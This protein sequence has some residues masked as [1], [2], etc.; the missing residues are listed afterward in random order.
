[1]RGSSQIFI[2]IDVQKALASGIEFFLSD[3]GVVLTE[4]DER[5]FLN[6]ELFE[7][8]EDAKG[9]LVGGWERLQTPAVTEPQTV[10]EGS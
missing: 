8:V 2:F 1:M 4:G 5:G 3:N 6:P 10:G 9:V 7:R